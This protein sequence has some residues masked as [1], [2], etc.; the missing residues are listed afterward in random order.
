MGLVLA[1]SWTG[2]VL[3]NAC[4]SSSSPAAP[5]AGA[6]QSDAGDDADYDASFDGG[7][8]LVYDGSDI[9]DVFEEATDAPAETFPADGRP[10]DVGTSD[11]PDGARP[12][13]GGDASRLTDA[14]PPG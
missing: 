13:D 12:A 14:S 3:V 7:I 8:A 6:S 11:A 2:G 5:D 9:E 4:G 1:V 10:A